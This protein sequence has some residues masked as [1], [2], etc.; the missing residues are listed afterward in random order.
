MKDS[1]GLIALVMG[2]ALILTRA[3]HPL[4]ESRH[5]SKHRFMDA[6]H[7]TSV[8]GYVKRSVRVSC[9]IEFTH[10]TCFQIQ[11]Q[12]IGGDFQ[13]YLEPVPQL[14]SQAGCL[15]GC[16]GQ[17]FGLSSRDPSLVQYGRQTGI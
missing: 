5:I 16:P 13:S 2:R 8:W 1:A 7:I 12:H 10:L 6:N 11:E 15:V 4:S 3:L 14:P 9:L 17:S